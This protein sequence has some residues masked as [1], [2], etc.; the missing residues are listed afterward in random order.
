V[1]LADFSD[2]P[3]PG[4]LSAPFTLSVDNKDNAWIFLGTGRYVTTADKTDG[5]PNYLFGLKD[6][7]YNWR[8][9]AESDTQLPAC[10]HN[11]SPTSCTISLSN[12]FNASQYIVKS[13]GTIDTPNTSDVLRGKT[14]DN[15]L[16]DGVLKKDTNGVEIYQGWYRSLTTTTG[17]PSERVINK[18][19][20]FGGIALFPTFTPDSNLCLSGGNSTL[21]ALYYQTGTAFKRAVLKDQ[22]N[23][24]EIKFTMDMGAGLASSSAL[25]VG[26]KEG[27][28]GTVISQLSTGEI[29][30]IDVVP[31]LAVKSGTQYWKE[32]K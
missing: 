20:A 17:G 10:L 2:L 25:H 28:T 12:L 31:A 5:N 1:P 3:N 26:K 24:S 7:F 6:P 8:G 19:A 11:Y 22:N 27:Q 18:P 4:Y 14:F 21:Y 15:F 9:K 16:K 32:G 13:D 29:V 30:Q 23:S